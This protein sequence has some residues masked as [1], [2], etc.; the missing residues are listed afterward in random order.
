MVECSITE[1]KNK[2]NYTKLSKEISYALRHAPWEYELELDNVGFVP[3]RQLLSAINEGSDYER[4]ITLSDFEHIIEISDKKRFEIKDDKI[5]ALYG[6]S[7]PM[8]ISKEP[9]LPPDIL[10]HGTSHKAYE[11]IINSGLKPMGR[12]Y[13]HLSVD[14]ATAVQVGKRRDR[15]PVILK[16]N[17]KKA[18]EDKIIFYEGNDKVVLA[19]YVPDKYIEL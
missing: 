13:V 10:Y 3:V 5:R 2:M 6:H 12:Q 9:I 4:E 1:R 16:I 17:A 11:L 15:N 14:I 19:D 18:S 7:I 8:H